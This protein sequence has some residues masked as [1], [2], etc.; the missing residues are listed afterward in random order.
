MNAW[1]EGTLLYVDGM[2]VEQAPLFPRADGSVAPPANP[3]AVLSRW[4]FDLDADCGSYDQMAVD[5]FPGEFPRIDDR[6][7]GYSYRHGWLRGHAGDQGE[8]FNTTVPLVTR[9]RRRYTYR[10]PPCDS[11][12]CVVSVPSYVQ[13]YAGHGQLLSAPFL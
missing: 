13:S 11:S 6:Y 3:S 8:K 10:L 5:D 9:R 1:E 2:Q 12:S 4:H 7:T